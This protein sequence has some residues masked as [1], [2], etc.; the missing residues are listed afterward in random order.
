MKLASV[1]PCLMAPLK[2]NPLSKYQR[3]IETEQARGVIEKEELL[4]YLLI[5]LLLNMT[6]RNLF[7]LQNSTTIF[8]RSL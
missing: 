4:L 8:A 7:A 3:P 5:M 6:Q 2:E 1:V